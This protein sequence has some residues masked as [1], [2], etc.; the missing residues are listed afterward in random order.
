MNT[1]ELLHK[2]AADRIV[3]LETVEN[4]QLKPI[5]IL[6]DKAAF[7]ISLNNDIYILNTQVLPQSLSSILILSSDNVFDTNRGEYDL[8]D[9]YRYQSFTDYLEIETTP[10]DNFTSFYL[11]FVKII[12][13]RKN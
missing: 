5:R 8:M 1:S 7:F 2:I 3:G 9:E 6:I 10:V 11:E 13:H 4:Y 12:P